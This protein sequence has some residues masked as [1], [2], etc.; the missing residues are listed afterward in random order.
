MIS[1]NHADDDILE[2]LHQDNDSNHD[3]EFDGN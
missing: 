1:S 2:L 3:S